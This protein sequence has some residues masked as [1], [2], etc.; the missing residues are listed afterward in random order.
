L[1]TPTATFAPPGDDTLWVEYSR[2]DFS[3]T[4]QAPPDREQATAYSSASETEAWVDRLPVLLPFG[5]LV[6]GV[7]VGEPTR[8][9]LSRA[10]VHKD[11]DALAKLE[12]EFGPLVRQAIRAR[13]PKRGDGLGPEDFLDRAWKELPE[14]R[15]PRGKVP[16]VVD[17]DDLC[18]RLLALALRL[19]VD[20]LEQRVGPWV[21]AM[22]RA[23]F[24]ERSLDGAG[25]EDCL[26][27]AWKE[28]WDRWAGSEG[29]LPLHDLQEFRR[30][31][32]TIAERRCIDAQ[33]RL[34]RRG[35]VSSGDLPSCT[36][37]TLHPLA[38]ATG[39]PSQRLEEGELRETLQGALQRLPD[40][41]R[42]VVHLR[43]LEG[44]KLVAVSQRLGVSTTTVHNREQ[45][46]L[47]LLRD[48]LV[49]AG[50]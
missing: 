27:Q 7:L 22:L 14:Q 20:H 24:P 8:E 26:Q 49:R 10:F 25:L 23:R 44:E 13:F 2:L 36:P 19:C 5:V 12:A 30:Y 40:E 18:R 32:L 34:Q 43:F 29:P 33:R 21:L 9:L 6:G 4:E 37:D 48:E 17:V 45:R 42:E 1:T 11:A 47:R 3:P 35:P 16:L 50:F 38:D 31:L 39:E 46:A 41:L 15:A 28:F